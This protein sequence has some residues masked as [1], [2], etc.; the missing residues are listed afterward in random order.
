MQ[1]K[2]KHVITRRRPDLEAW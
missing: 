2:E 1:G